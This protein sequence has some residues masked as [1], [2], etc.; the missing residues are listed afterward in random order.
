MA[1]IK[2]KRQFVDVPQQQKEIGVFLRSKRHSLG[3]SLDALT[4]GAGICKR[5]VMKLE[6]GKGGKVDSLL[7]YLD[8]LGLEIIIK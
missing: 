4:A 8:V 6:N 7:T 3:F 1:I 2:H 5:T